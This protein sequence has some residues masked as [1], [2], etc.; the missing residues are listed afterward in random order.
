MADDIPPGRT[1]P[2]HEMDPEAELLSLSVRLFDSATYRPA[3]H[4][5]P[6]DGLRQF[7][8]FDRG[9]PQELLLRESPSH[10]SFGASKFIA[11]TPAPDVCLNLKTCTHAI[12]P[13]LLN[14]LENYSH[15]VRGYG[16]AAARDW[17]MELPDAVHHIV[18]QAGFD[19]FCRGLSRLTVSKPLLAA[20]AERDMTITPYDFSMLTRIGV[21]GDPIPFDTDM[22]EWYAAQI[23]LLGADHS[24]RGGAVRTRLPHVSAGDDHFRRSG[25]HRAPLLAERSGGPALATLY[26]YMGSA[27]RY[28]G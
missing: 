13:P 7:R 14:T 26:G 12:L 4:M 3:I 20:L 18:D 22:D 6:P 23:H 2:N 11:G 25:E 28:S 15:T 17:Y 1:P 10:M 16:N 24:G 19:A 9:M 21:G 8:S 5:L 27:S